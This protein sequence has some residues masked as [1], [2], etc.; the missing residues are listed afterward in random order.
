[1]TEFLKNYD[2]DV[3]KTEKRLRK[4]VYEVVQPLMPH[5]K[6][7]IEE[8]RELKS[9][10]DWKY[11]GEFD[12]SNR[13]WRDDAASF[14]G[15]SNNGQNALKAAVGDT[16]FDSIINGAFPEANQDSVDEEM[17]AYITATRNDLFDE[18][19]V[20]SDERYKS[21]ALFHWYCSFGCIP[22]RQHDIKVKHIV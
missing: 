5:T 11:G 17:L 13:D 16:L 3:G 19:K 9:I 22:G 4:L 2:Y 20:E 18:D 15:V 14:F 7:S 21:D 1:M 6:L 8:H 12:G 10:I